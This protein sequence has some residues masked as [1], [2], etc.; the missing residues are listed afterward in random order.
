MIDQF[1][2]VF[3]V[4]SQVSERRKFIQMLVDVAQTQTA[5]FVVV[6]T[7][8]IDFLVDCTYANLDA[9]VN[10]QMVVISG[11]NDQE[12]RDVIAKPLAPMASRLSL[13]VLTRP[14]A[15]GAA[16]IGKTG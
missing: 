4:C 10:E 6:A 16:V 9:I 14:F 1:E 11:M 3:T 7:M 5:D 13:A 8:R 12:L 15:C 2:E